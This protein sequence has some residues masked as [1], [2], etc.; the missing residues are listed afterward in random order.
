[1]NNKTIKNIVIII[2]IIMFMSVHYVSYNFPN[3]NIILSLLIAILPKLAVSIS[4]TYVYMK[5]KDIKYNIILHIVYN[6]LIIS[7]D[8]IL[9]SVI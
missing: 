4:L 1:M 7:I 3:F 2:N 6:F 5:T 8:Y 9:T